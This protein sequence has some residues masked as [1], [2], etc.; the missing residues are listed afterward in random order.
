MKK[1]KKCILFPVLLVF[2]ASCADKLYSDPAQ[3]ITEKQI[4]ELSR[5]NPDVILKPM[6]GN[7]EIVPRTVYKNVVWCQNMRV[8]SICM[9]YKGND[10]VYLSSGSWM[11]RD[12]EMMNYRSDLAS[13]EEPAE[14]WACMYQWVYRANQFLA[15]IPDFETITNPTVLES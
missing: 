2:L 6:A 13:D 12:Y 1:Y 11:R 4:I 14:W 10:I 15:L 7:I 8:L 3:E 9:D 5:A